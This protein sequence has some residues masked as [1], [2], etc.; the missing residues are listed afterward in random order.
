V[1]STKNIIAQLAVLL[2]ISLSLGLKRDLQSSKF[3]IIVEEL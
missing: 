2:T 3:R 1:A